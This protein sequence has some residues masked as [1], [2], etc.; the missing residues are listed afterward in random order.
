LPDGCQRHQS[1]SFKLLVV[2]VAFIGSWP[3][4][5]RIVFALF[6]V[7]ALVWGRMGVMAPIIP[8]WRSTRLILSLNLSRKFRLR[9]RGFTFTGFSVITVTKYE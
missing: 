3:S 5:A 8:K 9:A 1:C 2:G 6:S 4:L 7:R